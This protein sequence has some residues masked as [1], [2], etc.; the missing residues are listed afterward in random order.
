MAK[1]KGLGRGLDAIFMENSIEEGAKEAKGATTLRLSDVEPRKDQPRKYFDAEALAQ[2]SESIAQHGVIQPI[3]VREAADGFYEII[4]GER[5]W[6]AAKLAGLSEIPAIV[7]DA[8][9]LK[10]AQI[11]I[12]ENIQREDLNAFE[13][14]QAYDALMDRYGFTQEEISERLGK[15]RSAIANT[16]RLLDLPE[17]AV[18]LLKKGELSAGHA[19]ALLGLKDRT[20]ILPLA[21]DII[22]R[23][24]SVR[25]TEAMV[26][27]ANRPKVIKETPPDTSL[28]V[29][30]LAELE[31]KVRSE[32]GRQVKISDSRGKKTVQIEY[33]DNEDLEILLKKLCGD[34]FFEE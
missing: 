26:K 29:N 24:C 11:S 14:A 19:R 1:N 25:E 3:L 20:L 21:K 17:E 31:R 34:N 23:D 12:I 6:R 22:A 10:A 18:E 30:Y 9:E 16:L 7:L 2:L 27:A 8:D 15:S 28:R 5:R 13:E 4:A 33:Q 32:L